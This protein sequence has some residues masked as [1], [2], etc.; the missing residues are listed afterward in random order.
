MK[1]HPTSVSSSYSDTGIKNPASDNGYYNSYPWLG[2]DYTVLAV[3]PNEF[4]VENFKS[5][6]NLIYELNFPAYDKTKYVLVCA[7]NGD[8]HIRIWRVWMWML[9]S[10]RI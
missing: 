10:F 5:N 3:L 9:L 2:Q 4:G 8:K 7:A 6:E 1:T